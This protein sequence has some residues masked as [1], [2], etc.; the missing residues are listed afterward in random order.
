MQNKKLQFSVLSIFPESIKS[1]FDYGMMQIAKDNDKVEIDYY[2]IRDYSLDKHH[3]VDDTS[4]GGGAGML[5]QV[6]PI[7]RAWQDIK[8]EKKSLTVLLSAKGKKWNQQLAQKWLKDYD[9]INLICGR[10]EGVDERV[11]V[12][13]DE[14]VRVGDY[15]LSGGEL[16]AAIIMDSM[17]RLIPGVLGSAESLEE[18]SHNIVGQL[19][20][21]QYTKP[22]ELEIEGKNY[23]VP[24]V[25]LS[26]NHKKIK[27]WRSKHSK[28]IKN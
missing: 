17:I 5:M 15:V 26:G 22:A 13:V 3:H 25:L 27:E 8:K 9:Q 20:Y 2:N 28:N 4:Y 7:Y 10:Y 6:E 11:K 16:G 18:E 12:F 24:E 1:Y 14:E 21:P 23:K 19:E